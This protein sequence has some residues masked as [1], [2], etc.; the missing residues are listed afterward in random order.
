MASAPPEKIHGQ[1]PAPFPQGQAYL[2]QGQVI[3]QMGPGPSGSHLVPLTNAP[4]IVYAAPPPTT[5]QNYKHK[6]ALGLG[7]TQVV[8]GIL[9]ILLQI[10]AII[11]ASNVAV[12]GTGIWTGILFILAGAFGIASSQKKTKCLI[13]TTMVMS[14][15]SAIFVGFLVGLSAT[16]VANNADPY[17]DYYYDDKAPRSARLSADGIMLVV[18][19]VELVVAILQSVFCCSAVCCGQTRTLVTYAAAPGGQ[20]LL[21]PQ[22]MGHPTPMV[23][24][25]PGTLEAGE[26]CYG[27]TP[28]TPSANTQAP[29]PPPYEENVAPQRALL[30]EN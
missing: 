22:T 28:Y 4:V 2:M 25:A 18:A 24:T 30:P 16:S 29:G 27:A 9:A 19:I 26:V 5:Y 12:V 10:M 20:A 14:I 11:F 1:M 3:Q 7:V 8:C 23:A 21:A 17:E 15:I 13:I 6:A